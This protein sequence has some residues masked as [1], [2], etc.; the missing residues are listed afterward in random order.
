MERDNNYLIGKDIVSRDKFA[1]E[2]AQQQHM[3]EKKALKQEL[4]TVLLGIEEKKK[5]FRKDQE[6]E[7]EQYDKCD[8]IQ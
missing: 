4:D 1:V 5:K 7:K 8:L 2:K 3:L 6:V